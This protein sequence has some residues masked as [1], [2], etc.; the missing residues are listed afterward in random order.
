[1]NKHYYAVIMAG[2]V[3]SR[4]W[5]LSRKNHPKQFHDIFGRG[6]CLLRET[7]DR[8]KNIC[9]EKNI[10]VVTNESYEDLV[11]ENIPEINDYQILGEPMGRNT[12]PCVA[13]ATHRIKKKDPNASIVVAP[14]DHLIG[15]E[16]E[17]AKVITKA[18]DFA[19]RQ[20]IL[21]TIGIKPTRPDTGYGY[22]QFMEDKKTE[23]FYKVKTFTEK[24]NRQLADHFIESGEFLWNAGIFCWSA[25]AISNSLKQHLSEIDSLFTK[26]DKILGTKHEKKFIRKTYEI[27][28]MI[29]IDYGI[30]EKAENVYVIPADFEWSDIGTWN[31]LYELADKD[32]NNNVLRGDNIYLRNTNKC[33]IYVSKGKLAALNSVS[34]LIIV[35]ND[36][37]LLVADREKEQEIR[38]V[39]NDLKLKHGEKFT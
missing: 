12:A 37:V 20:E 19:L 6:K 38:Q 4:F 9:P 16:E 7:Y 27:C 24:P 18:L 32:D 31:A 30:M 39:V 34:N 22:I 29:S 35:E 8:L 28:P 3:G 17:F 33:I 2:G 36:N 23:G 11:K 13:Y 5:P 14:A 25:K 26:G 1:M 10:Y 15:N 21:I